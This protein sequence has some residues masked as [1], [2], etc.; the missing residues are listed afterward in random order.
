[1][2]GDV[3][4]E[5]ATSLGIKVCKH[6]GREAGLKLNISF[7]GMKHGNY[8][9]AI[10]VILV[11]LLGLGRRQGKQAKDSHSSGCDSLGGGDIRNASVGRLIITKAANIFPIKMSQEF[12]LRLVGRFI[13]SIPNLN[14][15]NAL[16]IL[17]RRMLIVVPHVITLSSHTS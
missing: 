11:M 5:G 6:R 4:A 15:F 10:V 17:L 7:C 2:L 3:L 1:M 9:A 13:S 12:F 8:L 16:G 14:P